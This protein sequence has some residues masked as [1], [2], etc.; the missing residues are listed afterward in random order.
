MN[1]TSIIEQIYTLVLFPLIILGG[2]CLVAFLSAKIGELKKKTNCDLANKYLDML[3]D[4]IAST[5]LATT[6]TYV[7]ALK[8]EGKF[9]ADAQ[10]IAFQKTYDA[11]MAVLTEEAKKYITTAVG[12][13]EVYVTNKIE[14]EV[15]LNKVY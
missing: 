2:V 9:D 15:V 3:D 6:Q 1:W 12:D 7:E 14:S 4:T 5:V 13:I 11:V 10:K 8:K